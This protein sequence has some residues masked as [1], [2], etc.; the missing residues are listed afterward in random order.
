MREARR[1]RLHSAE[2]DSRAALPRAGGRVGA[3]N[4][5]RLLHG[6][7]VSCGGLRQRSGADRGDGHTVLW[8]HYAAPSGPFLKPVSDY[9]DLPAIKKS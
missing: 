7:T 9:V 1:T 5:E 4:G 6:R 3:Q 2:T 8:M